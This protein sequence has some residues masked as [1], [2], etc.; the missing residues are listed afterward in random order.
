VKLSDVL[1]DLI[2]VVVIGVDIEFEQRE[3]GYILVRPHVGGNPWVH[4]SDGNGLLEPGFQA[5]LVCALE[6]YAESKGY[7][8]EF[9]YNPSKVYFAWVCH[10]EADYV[11]ANGFTRLQAALKAFL[12]TFGGKE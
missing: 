12:E 10:K 3:S 9:G 11:K 7:W 2:K 8:F 1:E 6:Q 4:Y 5:L